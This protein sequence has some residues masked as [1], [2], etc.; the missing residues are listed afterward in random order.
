MLAVGV[1]DTPA[2]T[3]VAAETFE[4]LIVAPTPVLHLEVFGDGAAV[5]EAVSHVKIGQ[6][7]DISSDIVEI[8]FSADV[9]QIR[10]MRAVRHVVLKYH[11][12]HRLATI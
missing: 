1:P 12:R 10:I 9:Y 4:L 8:R 6:V 2:L 3:P 7:A 11:I 5:V